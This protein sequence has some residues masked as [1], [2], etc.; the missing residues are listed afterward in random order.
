MS[1][2]LPLCKGEEILVW[3]FAFWW[4]VLYVSFLVMICMCVCEKIGEL[5]NLCKKL[6]SP[7]RKKQK[8]RKLSNNWGNLDTVHE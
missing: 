3:M 8:K 6:C 2:V 7:P 4:N 1:E 5:Y